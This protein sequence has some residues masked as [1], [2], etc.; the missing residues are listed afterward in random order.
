MPPVVA[1]AVAVATWV[2]A[3]T[4]LAI[5]I[6]MAAASLAM[7]LSVKVPS[8]RP[9]Q[10]SLKQLL[11]SSRPAKSVIYGEVMVSGALLFAEEQ[12]GDTE[13]DDGTYNEWLY[14]AVGVA[15]HPITTVKNVYLNE[16]PIGDFGAKATYQLHSGSS[17]V[18]SYL[19]ANAPSWQADMIGGDSTWLRLSLHFDRE[20]YSNGVPTPKIELNGKTVWD[21]RTD[22][23]VYSNNAALVIADFLVEYMG[24]TKER[25]ITSGH[26]NFIS[27]ANLCGEAVENPDGG[28]NARYEINAI[29]RLDQKPADVLH[30]MLASCGGILVRIGG[31]VGLLPAAYYGVSTVTITESDLAGDV[32]IQ[33]EQAYSDAIN[34]IKGTFVDADQ[35]Y[36]ETDFP[37]IVDV[38]ARS[39]DGAELSDDLKLPFVTNA[40]QAQRLAD[41]QLKRSL[42][43][44]AVDLSLNLRGLNCYEGRVVEVNLPT[45]GL[46]GEYRVVRSTMHIT[47]GVSVTLQRDDVSIYDDAIG[48]VFIPPPLT[49]L[50]VGGIAAPSGVQFLVDS[51]GEVIQGK[52]TWQINYPQSIL[53]DIRVK[54]I[55]DNVVV[56]V[57][58]S[59]SNFWTV[60]GLPANNYIVE[61]RSVSSTGKVSNWASASFVVDVPPMPDSVGVDSSNWNI[62]LTPSVIGGIP[63]GTLFRYKYLQDDESFLTGVPTYDATDV[64][65]AETL[66]TGSSFNHGGL[67]PDRYHHYWVQ[68]INSYGES[69]WLYVITGTTRE[70]DLVTTVVERLEAIEIISSNF[71]E[72][73]QGY[74]IW[75]ADPND[76]TA[77]GRVEFNDGSFRGDIIAKTLTLTGGATIDKDDVNGIYPNQTELLIKSDGYVAGSAGWAIDKAG[78]VDFQNGVFRGSVYMQH[79]AV[80]TLEVAG[81]AITHTAVLERTGASYATSG[82]AYTLMRLIYNHGGTSTVT[83]LITV[84]GDCTPDSGDTEMRLTLDN[85]SKVEWYDRDEVTKV[86]AIEVPPGDHD[87]KWRYKGSVTDGLMYI[88]GA[89]R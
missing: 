16:T 49:N 32:S 48:D 6:A 44:G 86:F 33:P 5:G 29:F 82:E 59:T 35:G 69:D 73:S 72:G 77:D 81:S 23:T 19:L 37:P 46:I 63:S 27:A 8:P 88:L 11:R 24:F 71:V 40:Y 53:T 55:S 28:F 51:V 50:P 89:K 38:S 31:K 7:A 41:I 61:V 83:C 34:T 87:I 20:L 14:M 10:Q 84:T 12:T 75:A 57:G 39:R 47:E 43:G 45:I 66:F 25:L 54:R 17:S 80:G 13:N 36:V 18:D 85:V 76:P 22:T 64:A 4:A 65:S 30:D 21:M 58:Q 70:Q 68:G 2:A 26:G 78:D 67:T 74:K 9:T 60:N 62:R 79:A 42:A 52:I 56:V 3:N 1:V 15:E